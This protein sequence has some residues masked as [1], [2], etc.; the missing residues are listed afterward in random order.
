MTSHIPHFLEAYLTE[1]DDSLFGESYIDP[2]GTLIVWS[3]LGR[4]VF[5]D[6]VNSVSNDVRNYTLNLFHH[7]LIR[8]LVLDDEV[9]LSTS[10]RSQYGDKNALA[11]KQ[12]CLI[13]L[14]NLF[15]FSLLRHEERP[16]VETIGVLGISKA[17]RRWDQEKERTQLIFTH[18]SIGQILVRQLGLGVSGRYK[19]P[20]L[21]IGFFDKDYQYHLPRF[22]PCWSRAQAFICQTG[23]SA[24]ARLEDAVYRFLKE[25]ILTL[26]HK[27]SILFESVPRPLSKDYAAAFGSSPAVGAYARDFWLAETGLDTGAAGAI[28]DVLLADGN[29]D[30]NAREIVE[31]AIE[32]A[33][34]PEDKAK[35]EQIA[36]VEP[37]LADCAL[38]FSLM[39]S[40]RQCTVDAV[41]ETWRDAFC[42]GDSHLPELADRAGDIMRLPALNGTRA[43]L[44]FVALQQAA[45]AGNTQEQVRALTKYHG[46]VMK[47][48]NQSAWLSIEDGTKIKVHART[49]AAPQPT[50]RPPG[51]WINNYYLPQ[52]ISLVNG[53]Q[54]VGI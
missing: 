5:D 31:R 3:A 8:K 1:Y 50:N 2:I 15:V 46:L 22:Q 43:G 27:G 16:G 47:G 53:L 18:E 9:K 12:A 33:M 10:L 14:E 44:R 23:H 26:R 52:F 38:L 4:Q 29:G 21:K 37:F 36:R 19:T 48:R 13:I 17:R 42:R 28:F 51:S 39:T 20:L 6:R 24:L 25:Q 30:A 34:Q 7:H 45:R 32:H 41:T 40:D 54:G 49:A 11:F 35:L